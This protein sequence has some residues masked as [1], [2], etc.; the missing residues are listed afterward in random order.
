[1][2]RWVRQFEMTTRNM[3]HFAAHINDRLIF[4]DFPPISRVSKVLQEISNF[5]FGLSIGDESR[6]EGGIS[7]NF[8]LIKIDTPSVYFK[9]L[10]VP[11]DSGTVLMIDWVF[12]ADTTEEEA[13]R[14]AVSTRQ[15]LGLFFLG[16]IIQFY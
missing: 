6:R 1:M 8:K 3:F 10:K 5:K 11:S 7:G 12:H 2:L 4:R 16:L 13:H 15:F 14:C 9:Q